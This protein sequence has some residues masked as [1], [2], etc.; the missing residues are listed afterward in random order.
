MRKTNVLLLMF[1]V[2]ALISM[3]LIPPLSRTAVAG[4]NEQAPGAA[5]SQTELKAGLG[6]EKME[7][8]GASDSF[9][10]A[11]DTKIYGWARVKDVAA[12]SNVTI[13][14][15]QGDREAF[16]KE[17]SVPS[18][19]YRIYAY[20]TFRANDGGDWTAVVI[21]SGGKEIA[22]TAFKVEITK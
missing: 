7:L 13:V 21:G 8:T 11:P 20:K 3:C 5:A 15:K 14:F 16:K 10:I 1:A 22:S 17:I 4:G 12:G 19:P 9:K 2:T 18:V 6:V